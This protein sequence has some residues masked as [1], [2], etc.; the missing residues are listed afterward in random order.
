MRRYSSLFVAVLMWWSTEVYGPEDVAW[1]LD[2]LPRTR[3]EEAKI[4]PI[5][6]GGLNGETTYAILYRAEWPFEW[7]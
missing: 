2:Q 6:N 1:F 4:I 7:D 5:P 3:A